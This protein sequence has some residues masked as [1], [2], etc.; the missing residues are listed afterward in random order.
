MLHL[1]VDMF[2]NSNDKEY[3]D[4]N[5][6]VNISLNVF[7]FFEV[8]LTTILGYIWESGNNLAIIQNSVNF[9][10]LLLFEVLLT[11]IRGHL[12][13]QIFFPGIWEFSC[14]Y[15]KQKNFFFCLLNKSFRIVKISPK[16]LHAFPLAGV[17]L[18]CI[19]SW[20][21][22]IQ[23]GHVWLRGNVVVIAYRIFE[24]LT[25]TLFSSTTFRVICSFGSAREDLFSE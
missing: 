21:L 12:G 16:W 1:P 13:S 18:D 25:P 6:N 15:Q 5:L 2:S 23:L 7:H 8:L 11:T 17:E 24:C 3:L 22:L 19:C 4:C 20:G 9:L 10:G 14:N